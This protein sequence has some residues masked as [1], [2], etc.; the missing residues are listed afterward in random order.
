MPR[1]QLP[2]AE[3]VPGGRSVAALSR[4]VRT[5]S[6]AGALFVVLLILALT[7]PVPYVVLSPGPTLNTL[8]TDDA[9]HAIIV[10]HGRKPART[11]GH[12]NLTTVSVSGN[13]ITP[14]QAVAGWLLHDEVVVPRTS[15]YPPGVSEKQTN[16]QNTQQF[17]QSQDSAT[18]AAFCELG[19]PNGFGVI[20]VVADG[21]SH[22]VLHPGDQF[23]SVDGT[24]ATSRSALDR[25]LAGLAPGTKIPLVV[26]RAG[27][28]V[29]LRVTL[30]T[31]PRE[32]GVHRGGYLGVVPDNT[33]LAPFAV[34]LGLGNEIGGPS[35]GL[36]F[37]LGIID[38]VG[39]SDLTGGRFVAGTGTIT[40]KGKVGAIGGI[41]LKMIAARNK[42]ASVFLA[43]AG[44]CSDVRGATPAGL[45]VVKV[46]RL[47]QAV[48]DLL[49]I[50]AGEPV[51]HC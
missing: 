37:A 43:P 2:S 35:A 20:D 50:K 46:A 39:R 48:T 16:Q 22:N 32:S 18:A 41:A 27:R 44:N 47:H 28:T 29:R 13:S 49:R 51:P 14:F 30:G 23:V 26:K 24:P 12:L 38:K 33:C 8:G 36:M 45:R 21:P 17:Q 34:D 25:I 10:F 42:G 15:V 4:R 9:G 11:T 5:L 40:A 7:M 6:I 19:Y 31:P 3:R 1:L